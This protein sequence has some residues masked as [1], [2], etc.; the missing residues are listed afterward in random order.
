MMDS[1]KFL[2]YNSSLLDYAKKNR[3]QPT[4][5][6]WIFWNVI[7][8]KKQFLGYKFRRQKVIWPY[9]LDFYCAKLYLWIE[10]DGWYHDNVQD[11][12]EER[13]IW[14]NSKYWIK[15]VRFLN[16]DI[17]KNMEWVVLYLED[18][19]KDREKELWL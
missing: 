11:Y 4:K 7:L 19:I 3:K 9:I 6:E 16:E 14:L 18:I 10:L 8:K 5:A 15:I 1:D 17:E 2:N 13:S 12:D